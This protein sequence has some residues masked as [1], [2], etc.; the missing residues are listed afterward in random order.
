MTIVQ[1]PFR[2]KFTGDMTDLIISSENSITFEMKVNGSRVVHE[3]YSPDDNQQIRVS[4]LA[5]TLLACIYGTIDSQQQPQASATV[6]LLVDDEQIAGQTVYC[7]RMRNV[8]DLAGANTILTHGRHDSCMPGRQH[9]LTF[10]GTCSVR[11]KDTEGQ[12]LATATVG[13][14]AMTKAVDCDPAVL[15]PNHWQRARLMDFGNGQHTTIIDRQSQ[16]GLTFRFLNMYDVPESLTTLPSTT[17]KPGI[18]TAD[19]VMYGITRRFDIQTTDTYESR[20]PRLCSY[21]EALKWRDLM[22]T[23][24]AQV[25][26][27]DEWA[28]IIIERPNFQTGLQ[29]IDVGGHAKFSFTLADK[30]LQL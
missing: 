23:R 1:S 12:T 6:Q 15:F 5:D 11:L 26:F 17:V 22:S 3:Q 8:T 2:T 16:P 9:L 21:D 24:R 7:S 4:G 19:D 27:Y 25:L 18:K 30:H 13:T 28:D 14:S 10:I 29:R 20:S